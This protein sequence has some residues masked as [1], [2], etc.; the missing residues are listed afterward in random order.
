MIDT[1]VQ[2]SHQTKEAGNKRLKTV[3]MA[4]IAVLSAVA[5]VLMLLEIPLFFVPSFYKLEFSEVPVLLGAFSMGP[6]AGVAIEGIKILIN[7]AIDGTITAG[8]GE[9]ANFLIGC[10]FVVPAA[11][12]YRRNKTRKNAITGLAAGMLTMVIFSALMNYY[13]LLPV[14][15][16]AFKMPVEAIVQMGT[17]VNSAITDLYTLILFATIPFNIL[18]G[19]CSS[20]ITVLSYKKLSPYLHH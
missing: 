14:Y 2:N 13:V 17:K 5:A 16:S 10:S 4:K 15:A 9:I 8:I 12:I 18:K 3:T 20:L 11:I 7:F 19:F 1:S 6:M